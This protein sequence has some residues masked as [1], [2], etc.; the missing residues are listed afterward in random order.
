MNAIVAGCNNPLI[1]RLRYTYGDLDKT[2]K[3]AL[4]SMVALVDPWEGYRKYR[5]ELDHYGHQK[6]LIPDLGEW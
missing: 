3:E 4:E 1:K 2:A 5:I 6:P